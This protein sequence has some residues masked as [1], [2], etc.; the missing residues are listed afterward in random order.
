MNNQAIALELIYNSVKH[1]LAIDF[2]AFASSLNG[3]DIVP[4]SHD[5][6]I[7]GG[8]LVKGNEI[9]VGYGVAPKASIRGH[10]KLTLANLIARYG[11]AV[12]KVASSNSKGLRFCERLG[13]VKLAEQDG[14]VLLEC[15]GS[16]YVH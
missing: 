16:K 11:S 14:I 6:Q 15:N 13:F 10:I 8:V 12:T 3:W 7:I 5:G 1:R 9:H 4:L 2:D